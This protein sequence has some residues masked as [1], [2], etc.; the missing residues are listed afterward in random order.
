MAAK[1]FS[2]QL[3]LTPFMN[4]IGKNI[5][6]VVLI[7]VVGY[8]SVENIPEVIDLSFSKVIFWKIGKRL[9]K[10]QK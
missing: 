7:H 3:N 10:S 5:H 2:F 6:V 4:A 9:S 1:M 8:I